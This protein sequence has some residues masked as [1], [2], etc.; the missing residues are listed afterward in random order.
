MKKVEE[1]RDGYFGDLPEDVQ[2][3]LM[4]IHKV[5]VDKVTAEYKLPKYSL[6]NNTSWAKQWLEIFLQMPSD[7]NQVGSVRVYKKG[8][9]YSC[10]IQM[11]GHV[12]NQ[13]NS[14]EE[15]FFHGMIRNAFT[16]IRPIIRKK[17]DCTITCESENGEPFEGFDIWPKNK[18]AEQIWNQFEDKKTKKIKPYEE[19]SEDIGKNILVVDMDELPYGLQQIVES[20]SK[21]FCGYN[22]R[23]GFTEL[24]EDGGSIYIGDHFNKMADMEKFEIENPGKYIRVDESAEVYIDLDNDYTR[25]LTNWLEN[26]EPCCSKKDVFA[27]TESGKPFSSIVGSLVFDLIPAKDDKQYDVYH[28]AEYVDTIDSDSY[29][30]ELQQIVKDMNITESV[31][32]YPYLESGK[33]NPTLDALLN[34][35]ANN[36]KKNRTKVTQVVLNTISSIINDNML[37]SWTSV[38]KKLN[39]VI[40]QKNPSAVQFVLPII[41]QD[42]VIS[43]L[44]GK[45][46]LNDFLSANREI[47]IKI[48]AN[49][50]STM[51]DAKQGIN[52]FKAAVKFYDKGTS[53]YS[54]LFKNEIADM[55]EETRQLFAK[56]KMSTVLI[57]AFQMLYC[58]DN[59]SLD[60]KIFSVDKKSI[61]EL[62]VFFK[63]IYTKYEK[64]EKQK[65]D[66]LNDV[67]KIVAAYRE[68]FDDIQFGGLV[69]AVQNFM[70]GAFV[71]VSTAT[72]NSFINE[73]EDREWFNESTN[74]DVKYYQE[75]F[76]VKKLKKIPRDIIA[77]IS[78][79]TECIKDGNDK[80]MIASYALA[81][82]ELTEWYI[83]LIDTGSKKYI[84]PHT[85]P[86]L[87]SLR[88]QL[89]AC[90][91]KIM[92]TPIPKAD[93]PIISI[94][95][96][97]GYEG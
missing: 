43:F 49:V 41:T 37:S 61:K 71:D 87:E 32:F 44:Y 36:A 18:V 31:V 77:Y 50:L 63:S 19:S 3:K 58:F 80:M 76:G 53:V 11:T 93:R 56:T 20:A 92:D 60:K 72:Y 35:I 6:F 79:E 78:I 96:P 66:I 83:E 2:I 52:F 73:Q 65:K 45:K 57:A 91:K 62:M 40:N 47:T 17:Y 13:R 59:V 10:M 23:Y 5:I 75:K 54:S 84:V 33:S 82:L 85:K 67:E 94:K 30:T 21:L 7:K 38:Y 86:Y 4:N 51:K 34:Q 25:L 26:N 69:S 97:D 88:T 42:N 68:S 55:K 24:Y 29:K 64:P 1:V 14:E 39:I 70:E 16:A 22:G 27:Y 28:Y 89:L 81:K 95:Y 12:T 46:D 8:K 15:E 48:G 74:Q 9:K 90:Y